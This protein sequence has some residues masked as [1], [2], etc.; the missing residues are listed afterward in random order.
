MRANRKPC[1]SD[2]MKASSADEVPMRAWMIIQSEKAMLIVFCDLNMAVVGDWME[3]CNSF[4]SI[5]F[6]KHV[7]IPPRERCGHDTWILR[8]SKTTI[9]MDN[10]RPQSSNANQEFLNR[11]RLLVTPHPLYSSYITPSDFWLFG[12]LK[13]QMQNV[14]VK[15]SATV[16]EFIEEI[17]KRISANMYREVF[18][19]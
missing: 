13:W 1:H 7:L 15:S 19:Y 14:K 10:V 11:S 5:Y 8:H 12:D 17:L 2:S 9:H 16:K 3:Q 4:N 18:H 6:K